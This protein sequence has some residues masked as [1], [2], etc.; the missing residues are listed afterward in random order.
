MNP[1]SAAEL[2]IL[3]WIAAHC[4][5]A[6][7]DV[8]MPAITRLGDSGIIWILLGFAILLF[9]R[10][11]RA[12][13][14]QVL[15]AL[16]LS[17]IFCNLLLKHAVGR[18]RPCDLNTAVELLIHRPGDPSFPSGHTSASFAAA[19]VL[20]LTKW[21]GRWAALT[22]AVLI[23]FSRLYLDVHFPTDVLGGALVGTV[24]ALLAVA[25][26]RKWLDKTAFGRILTGTQEENAP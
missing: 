14:F 1:L 24:C 25:I 18:I 5:S 16:L 26:W 6:W 8:L 3:D 10:K 11:E 4:Q 17:L 7:M 23:A 9:S 20:V 15:T 12:T 19:M 21:R 2:G 22:L 13:G